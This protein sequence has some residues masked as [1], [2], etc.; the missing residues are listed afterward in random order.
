M[1]VF[2]VQIET[3]EVELTLILVLLL[4][5][6]VVLESAFKLVGQKLGGFDV[7]MNG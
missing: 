7:P 4:K 3:V 5:I 1:V 6:D 2:G